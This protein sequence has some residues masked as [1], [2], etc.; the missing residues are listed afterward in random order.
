MMSMYTKRRRFNEEKKK[1][2]IYK[3]SVSRHWRT[4]VILL[5]SIVKYIYIFVTTC[6]RIWISLIR[7]GSI[8][9][10]DAVEI[11]FENILVKDQVETRN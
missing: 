3:M 11:Q 10:R 6:Q 4:V 2:K 9:L 5:A 8:R 1:K 7:F